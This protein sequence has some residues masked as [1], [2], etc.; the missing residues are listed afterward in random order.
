MKS[1]IVNRMCEVKIKTEFD[2]EDTSLDPLEK[3]IIRE[4]YEFYQRCQKSE[5]TFYTFLENIRSLAE[6]CEFHREEKEFLIR[7]RFLCGLNNRSLQLNLLATGGNPTV[8]DVLHFCCEQFKESN[9]DIKLEQLIVLD[10][11][12]Y[13]S[14]NTGSGSIVENNGV[15]SNTTS[16]ERKPDELGLNDDGDNTQWE[17]SNEEND[18]G[19]IHFI[20]IKVLRNNSIFFFIL[21]MNNQK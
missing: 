14:V 10:K 13:S 6:S 7:D 16:V 17:G 21:Q 2:N 12:N 11:E 19:I 1:K 9:A 18:E 4:R 20:R 8:D 15:C 3:N 5:E